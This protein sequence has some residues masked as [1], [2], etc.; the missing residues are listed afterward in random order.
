[1]ATIQHVLAGKGSQILSIGPDSTVLD[2]IKMMAEHDVGSLVVLEGEKLV[3]IVT[4]RHYARNV[5]LKGKA[6]P[7]TSVQEIMETPVQC[8][9]PRHTVDEAMALMTD[10]RIRH[11]PVVEGERL[12]GVV[13]IGDLVK[14]IIDEQ[15]FVITQLKNYIRG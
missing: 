13:S 1:M 10:K 4:E 9:S 3:G 5:I 6:S 12:A 11:L 15:G 14:S 7:D 2:A 8:V